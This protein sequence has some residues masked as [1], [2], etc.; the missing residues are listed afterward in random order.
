MKAN[1]MRRGSVLLMALWLIAVLSVMVISFAY[2]ARQQAGVDIYVKERNRVNR[3]VESG[4]MLGEAIL[5]GYKEAPEPEIDGGVPDWEDYFEEDRWVVEKYEL[6]TRHKCEIKNLRLDDEDEEAATLSVKI[7]WDSA[8][9]GGI[10]INEL[11]PSDSKYVLRW[12]TILQDA[13][14]DEEMEVEVTD[15][16]RS[17][18]KKHNLANLLI[19]S[20][21]DWVDEDETTSSGPITENEPEEDDGAEKDWYKTRYDEDEIPEKDRRYPPNGRIKKL[22]ELSYI[23]G[24]SDFPA[25]LTGGL[26]Y[27]DEDESEDNPRL[28]GIMSRFKTEGGKQIEINDKTRA[29]DLRTIP[30]LFPDDPEDQSQVDDCEELITAILAAL[31][32]PPEDDDDNTDLTQT[33]WP[34]KD[35]S[36]LN[37][38]I[39]DYGCDVQLP[40]EA[41]EYLTFPSS[42]SSTGTS[43][44]SGASK[45]SGSKSESSTYDK[46]EM[47]I[48]GHSLGMSYEVKARC[49]IDN[50]KVRYIEWQED[51]SR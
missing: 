23:R 39:D 37:K 42:T 13:G 38:R 50:D 36:D 7:E 4:R 40:D 20:F 29:E 6:K 41:S 14:I 47:T 1:T 16:D 31:K 18:K 35:V 33:W 2:E 44:S 48:T 30:G 19:A 43:G 15:A 9:G 34:Y 17:G 25:V 8:V 32:V 21:T 3:I 11:T 5:L 45:K 51:P 46:F 12:Q 24:F 22:E 49:I 26:L 27:P 28:K 10:D